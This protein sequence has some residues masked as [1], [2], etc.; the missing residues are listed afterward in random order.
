MFIRRVQSFQG[1]MKHAYSIDIT[2][3]IR[4]CDGPQANGCRGKKTQDNN[5]T[6]ALRNDIQIIRYLVGNK[7]VLLFS[8]FLFPLLFSF[9]FEQLMRGQHLR[10]Q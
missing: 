8:L 6:T 10:M 7:E 1:A 5:G 4:F 9:D 3:S 2:D